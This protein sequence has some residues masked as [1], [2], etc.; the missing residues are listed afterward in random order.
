[1]VE[2]VGQY[3]IKLRPEQFIDGGCQILE[4]EKKHL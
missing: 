4:E 1:M 3:Y 2:L